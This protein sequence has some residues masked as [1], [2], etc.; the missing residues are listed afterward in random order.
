MISL[1]GIF[2]IWLIISCQLFVVN[3]LAVFTAFYYTQLIEE[4]IPEFNAT[5]YNVT[6]CGANAGSDVEDG[7]GGCVIGIIP[8]YMMNNKSVYVNVGGVGK[9]LGYGGYNG[10]NYL[11]VFNNVSIYIYIT[12]CAFLYFINN[13]LYRW[14]WRRFTRF[15]Q[16]PYLW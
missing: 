16:G 6:V 12:F 3:V 4:Y 7:S 8:G 2:R 5:S 9:H 11:C 15:L 1:I 13:I 10:G 14:K